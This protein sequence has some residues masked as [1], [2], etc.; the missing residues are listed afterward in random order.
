MSYMTYETAQ[1]DAVKMIQKAKAVYGYVRFNNDY[2]D[3]V[4]LTKRD[5]LDALSATDEAVD[6][7]LGTNGNAYIN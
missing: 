3:Y 7:H 6:I 5:V 4:K 1:K 2:G